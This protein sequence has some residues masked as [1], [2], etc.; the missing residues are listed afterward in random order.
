MDQEQSKL[1]TTPF[2]EHLRRTVRRISAIGDETRQDIEAKKRLFDQ[3]LA[4]EEYLR[5][6]D[7]A[8]IRTGL[9]FGPTPS[10]SR[11]VRRQYGNLTWAITMGDRS[12]WER[13]VR[14]G[15]RRRA[16]EEAK[17][18]TF[19]HWELEFPDVFHGPDS[20]FD[21]VVGNPPYVS[22]GLG[23]VG[24]LD[25]M[26]KEYLRA[27]FPSSAEYKIST[28]AL[29]ME[30]AI[31]LSRDGGRQG[32]IL[33]DSFLI[34]K[35]FFKVRSLLLS[36]ILVELV[37]FGEDFWESG[38]VG[39]PVIWIEEKGTPDADDS[40]F[41]VTFA[42]TLE[43]IEIG[44]VTERLHE[45][46]QPQRNRRKRIRLF[47][48][49]SVASLVGKV[50]RAQSLVSDLVSM[51]HGVRSKV[52]RDKVITRT[53]PT[54]DPRWKRGLVESNQVTRFHVE[55]RGDHIL[56]DPEILFKGGWDP[57]K[58]EKC[59]ILVRRTGDSIISAI[60]TEHYYHTNALIY[61][62]AIVG[63]PARSL[64][65][66]CGI[67][68]SRLFTYYYR[69]VTAKEDR[70]FPQVEIDSLEEL[71]VP[72][73][74]TESETSSP[75][76][77]D[78]TNQ[79]DALVEEGRTAEACRLIQ[80]LQS[81]P[82]VVHHDLLVHLV[83]IAEEQVKLRNEAS[84]NFLDWLQ[85]AS[86]SEIDAW[87]RKTV[88]QDFASRPFED[89]V[90]VLR[91]NEENSRLRPH[92]N[93]EDLRALRQNFDAALSEIRPLNERIETARLLMDLIV[94]SLYDLTPEEMAIVEGIPLERVCKKYRLPEGE[95]AEGST[96]P[97]TAE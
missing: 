84:K 91:S 6:K 53:A 78:V 15:W 2:L 35:Y 20:G 23:R 92:R 54:G 86:S 61:G 21:A 49:A 27:A 90:E 64:R 43:S 95:I 38:D 18:R 22:F 14:S 66:V 41:L 80:E 24:K 94:Y 60:D 47:K 36:N 67:F 4:S 55:Y 87:N 97:E 63:D 17:E 34:G 71:R 12:Q 56:I 37:H 48:D 39:F 13:E 7:L 88:V 45:R 16:L 76:I 79:L 89:L 69:A 82:G 29:F 26:E 59:K 28:Y 73:L 74:P 1:Q 70:T 57:E 33:P 72:P 19:F 8:D 44:Q 96:S 50:E 81:G 3:L 5:I 25:D 77:D 85:V 42:P 58:I 52:G 93:A 68:N 46:T 32:L 11:D 65:Y 51:H 83:E 62:N 40:H 30:L 75:L 9:F 10:G 31:R